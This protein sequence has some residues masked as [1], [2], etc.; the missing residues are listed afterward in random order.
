MRRIAFLLLLLL[1]TAPANAVVVSRLYNFEAGTPIEAD[2]VDAEFDNILSAVNGNLQSDNLAANAVAT[3]NLATASVT[4]AKLQDYSVTQVKLGS[5]GQQIS[6]SSGT[7]QSSSVVESQITNLSGSLAV[8]SRPVFVGLQSEG[9]ASA[10]GGITI[11]NNGLGATDNAA[12][13]SFRR[14]SATV[15]QAM[16]TGRSITNSSD[17]I[18]TVVPCSSFW[19]IDVPTSGTHSY[20]AYYRLATGDSG[21]VSVVNCKLVLFEL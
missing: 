14:D 19:F 1:W 20:A 2:Q 6:S 7:F 4:T 16:I 5:K 15:N 17:D 3:A 13:I 21:I 12:I 10:P 9:G 11:R 18:Y 8:Y